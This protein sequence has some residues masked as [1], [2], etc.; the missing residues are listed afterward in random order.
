[1]ANSRAAPEGRILFAGEHTSSGHEGF[2]E[3][4]VETGERAAH[5]LVHALGS[6]HF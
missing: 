5:Q 4:A 1:M 3:G 6:R 2:L